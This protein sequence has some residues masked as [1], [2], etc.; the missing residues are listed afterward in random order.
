MNTWP[1]GALTREEVAKLLDDVLPWRVEW[2]AGSRTA[3]TEGRGSPLPDGV[4]EGIPTRA[5]R[6]KFERGKQEHR[7]WFFA[8]LT[9]DRRVIFREGP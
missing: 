5:K 3:P 6:R 4:L 7:T 2:C 8:F 1:E 9:A